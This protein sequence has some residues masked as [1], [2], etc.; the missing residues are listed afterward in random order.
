MPT[1]R[2]ATVASRPASLASP[3]PSLAFSR[4]ALT[5][6]STPL[7]LAQS[8]KIAPLA[9][10]GSGGTEDD[11]TAAGTG[12]GSNQTASSAYETVAGAAKSIVDAVTGGQSA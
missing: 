7:T 4:C 9:P 12:V 3:R 6:A 10:E 1:P 2:W 11:F 8:T 5:L